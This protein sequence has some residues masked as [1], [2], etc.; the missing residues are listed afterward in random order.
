[1]VSKKSPLPS[2]GA[3]TS[4]LGGKQAPKQKKIIG[5]KDFRMAPESLKIQSFLWGD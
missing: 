5:M 3:R 1:M 4:L 2:M